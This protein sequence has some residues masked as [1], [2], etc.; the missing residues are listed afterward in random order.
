[1]PTIELVLRDDHNQVIG[2]QPI[3]KYLLNLNSPIFHDIE[4]AVEN[5]R[6][7]VLPDI[8]LALLEAAQETF[9]QDKKRSKL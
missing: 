3:R 5:F 2:Q 8:E 4:G 7:T 6:K 9:I 1:M